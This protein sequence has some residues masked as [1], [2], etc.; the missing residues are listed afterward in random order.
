MLLTCANTFN[1]A[2]IKG[3]NRKLRKP[4]IIC[5]KRFKQPCSM[6]NQYS[7][8]GNQKDQHDFRLIDVYEFSNGSNKV[9]IHSMPNKA[10]AIP[11]RYPIVLIPRDTRHSFRNAFDMKFWRH[12]S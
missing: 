4:Y 5:K 7:V 1:I 12:I 8:G 9:V 2:R 6:R 10:R 11:D 3:I